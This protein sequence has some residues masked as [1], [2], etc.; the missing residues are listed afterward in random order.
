[1]EEGG[2]TLLERLNFL[3]E[4]Q[5]L[6]VA[7]EVRNRKVFYA[8]HHGELKE[9]E[10]WTPLWKELPSGRRWLR[11]LEG[12][13][14]S[15][16]KKRYA[17]ETPE[18]AAENWKLSLRVDGQKRLITGNTYPENWASFVDVMN[19]LPGV[20]MP[21]VNQVEL[22]QLVY[23]TMLPPQQV[24]VYGPQFK[25][26]ALIEKLV[27]NRGK[28]LLVLTRHKQGFGTERHAFDS[29]RNVPLLL[30]RTDAALAELTGMSSQPLHADD[31]EHIALRIVRRTGEETLL[32]FGAREH[33]P[34]CLEALL[35]EVASLANFMHCSLLPA[36][37]SAAE[38]QAQPAQEAGEKKHLEEKN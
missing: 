32:Q 5:A 10:L 33:W 17:A 9:G 1:M 11:H 28:H 8:T 30:K 35:S 31:K 29:I 20:A 2:T 23:Q 22:L 18:D 15:Q 4:E 25:S 38:A 13:R 7:V 6:R 37:E 16:W 21:K 24:S 36:R 3:L 27:I 14:I 34:A 19:E 26:G 12:V